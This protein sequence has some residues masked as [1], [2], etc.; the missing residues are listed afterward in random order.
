MGV[1]DLDS[2][3]VKVRDWFCYSSQCLDQ[4]VNTGLV[5]VKKAAT[6][7]ILQTSETCLSAMGYDL[8]VLVHYTQSTTFYYGEWGERTI[9]GRIVPTIPVP[10]KRGYKDQP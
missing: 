1:Q 9:Q 7:M 3:R 2:W 4:I 10:M 6:H 8:W 5:L